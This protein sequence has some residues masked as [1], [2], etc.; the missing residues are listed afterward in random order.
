MAMNKKKK[1]L[2]ESYKIKAAL[3]LST[4]EMPQPDIPVPKGFSE[5]TTGF[6]AQYKQVQYACSSAV[7]HGTSWEFCNTTTSQKGIEM[8]SSRVEAYKALRF[9]M[10]LEFARELY[11]IDQTIESYQES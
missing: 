11:K 10:E 4:G 2:L 9:K 3:H 5:I 1:D 8:Y 7:S 6:V